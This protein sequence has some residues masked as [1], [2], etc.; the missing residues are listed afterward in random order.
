MINLPQ[1]DYSDE[2]F[3]RYFLALKRWQQ[4]R[5][6][7][8]HVPME[9]VMYTRMHRSNNCIKNDE[10]IQTILGIRCL[11]SV[12]IFSLIT[13]SIDV[14][15]TAYFNYI[16]QNKSGVGAYESDCSLKISSDEVRNYCVCFF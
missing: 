8:A 5:E 11:D 1:K 10:T 13:D 2:A 15:K 6:I 14:S 3:C 12:A 4:I 16:R 9:N 7:S